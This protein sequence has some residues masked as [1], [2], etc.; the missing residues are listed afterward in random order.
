[1]TRDELE[2]IFNKWHTSSQRI[3]SKLAV[4]FYE[5]K[6][7]IESSAEIWVTESSQ[8][9]KRI[10]SKY[11][12]AEEYWIT[13]WRKGY[14]YY[15]WQG[16]YSRDLRSLIN[17][18]SYLLEDIVEKYNL[19]Q[20]TEERT[21]ERIT[22]YVHNNY[23]YISDIDNFKSKEW[24]ADTDIISQK[25]QDDCDGLAMLL[26]AL[27][28]ECGVPD[29]KLKVAAGFVFLPGTEQKE[30]DLKSAQI[31]GHAYCLYCRNEK[32]WVVLDPTWEDG[33]EP[34]ESRVL[35]KEDPRYN[36]QERPLFFTL[37]KQHIFIQEDVK[38]LNRKS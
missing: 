8:I 36:P 4:T 3:Q 31:G 33:S 37:T 7:F 35:H 21:L 19:K 5:V 34:I 32:E 12:T 16:D 9:E 26:K 22:Q 6:K 29:W 10:K 20:P 17:H 27:A 24:W 11:Q 15:K 30:N 25:L 1:M 14:I 13:R 18:P 38:I 28:L 2:K 23:Q